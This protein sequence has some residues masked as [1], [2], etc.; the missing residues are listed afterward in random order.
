M[1]HE[2]FWIRKTVGYGSTRTRQFGR[3]TCSLSQIDS[4]PIA[5]LDPDGQ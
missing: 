3:F 5:D 4:S 1:N 2:P